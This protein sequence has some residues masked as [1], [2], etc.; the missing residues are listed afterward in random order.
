MFAKRKK[1]YANMVSRIRNEITSRQT[2][3]SKDGRHR[4][5]S[6]NIASS[7]SAL[8]PEAAINVSTSSF[9]GSL[10]GVVSIPT[11]N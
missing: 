11:K 10:T 1:K 3:A 8:S 7:V 9:V 2:Q 6:A 4:D 5:Y